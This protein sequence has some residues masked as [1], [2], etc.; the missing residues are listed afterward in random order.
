MQ[1]HVSIKTACASSPLFLS[2][3]QLA[4]PKETISPPDFSA[5]FVKML[6]PRHAEECS[7]TSHLD[8]LYVRIFFVGWSLQSEKIRLPPPHAPK[9]AIDG[10]SSNPCRRQCKDNLESHFLNFIFDS[11]ATGS[12]IQCAVLQILEYFARGYRKQVSYDT[13]TFAGEMFFVNIPYKDAA[14]AWMGRTNFTTSGAHDVIAITSP[15]KNDPCTI[16][17]CLH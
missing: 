10:I 2:W 6:R 3:Q 4:G 13:E 11:S 17:L 8:D 7:W 14:L 5:A 15:R 9:K 12:I 1:K 16:D